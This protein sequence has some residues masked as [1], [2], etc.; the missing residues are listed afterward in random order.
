MP[1]KNASEYARCGRAQLG[2]D[3]QYLTVREV[4]SQASTLVNG[5]LSSERSNF[6]RFG[7]AILGYIKGD[8]ADVWRRRGEYPARGVKRWQETTDP[9]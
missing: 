3:E 2:Q 9:M 8:L 4:L 5:P 1:R 6:Y 7:Y